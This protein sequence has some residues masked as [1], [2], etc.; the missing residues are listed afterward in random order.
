MDA[1]IT[2]RRND[3]APIGIGPGDR[4]FHERAVGDRFADLQCVWPIAAAVYFDRDEVRGALAV[5]W[6]RL[7]QV[8]ADFE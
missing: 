7:G 3:P 4:R 8:F 6:D 2:G 5:G 1:G